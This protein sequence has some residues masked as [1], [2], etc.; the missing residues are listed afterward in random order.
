MLSK[1]KKSKKIS[2]GIKS[3][4]ICTFLFNLSPATSKADQVCDFCNT[5]VL[6]DNSRAE[7]FLTIY[8]DRLD[9][10]LKSNVGYVR[11][12]LDECSGAK[13]TGSK[14]VVDPDSAIPD[15][16]L[17]SKVVFL[18]ENSLNCIKE[19]ID[20]EGSNFDPIQELNLDV[21]CS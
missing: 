20:S 21:I 19:T 4:F 6:I 12:N 1:L 15:K 18:D 13:Q 2:C 11:V 14:G 17:S 16:E 8:E 10:L 9:K 5:T 7:C 3:L